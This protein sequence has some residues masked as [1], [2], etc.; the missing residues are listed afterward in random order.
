MDVSTQ[1]WFF[2]TVVL[3]KT[4]ESPL[5]YNEIKPFNLKGNEPW[6][7]I[8]KTDAKAEAPILWPPEVKSWLWK[9][10]W[11]WE[12][13]K[14]GGQGDEMVEWHHWLNGC[15]FEQAPGDGEGQESLECCSPWG[16]KESDRTDWLNNRTLFTV[17]STSYKLGSKNQCRV[18]DLR[19]KVPPWVGGR[20]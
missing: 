17:I 13:L 20:K 5:D 10:P 16:H 12:R 4:L 8:G 9:R 1:N 18:S 14:A 19:A 2:Q 7:F 3:E 15:G 6:I 11:C